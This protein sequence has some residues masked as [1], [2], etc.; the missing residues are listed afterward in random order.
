M[1]GDPL[2]AMMLINLFAL[3]GGIAMGSYLLKYY[4]KKKIDI[5]SNAVASVFIVAMLITFAVAS[6]AASATFLVIGVFFAGMSLADSK[7]EES[8]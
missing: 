2:L 3:A 8:K 6:Y 7:P 4:D 1:T 5:H